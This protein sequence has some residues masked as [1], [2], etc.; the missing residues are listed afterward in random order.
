MKAAI[1]EE[2]GKIEVCEIKDPEAKEGFS[3]IKVIEATL[4]PID[5]FTIMG[6]RTVK[7]IPHIPGVEV[8]GEVVEG[9]YK[10]KK[11]VVYPRIFCGE[12]EYC[13]SG[14][15][16][17]CTGELFGV[18]TNGGFAELCLVP[19]KNIFPIEEKVLPEVASSLPVGAL[20]SYHALKYANFGDRVAVIGA[21][22]NTGIFSVQIAKLKGCEVF[23]WSRKKANWLKE[24][25]ADEVLN[26]E[27]V[28]KFIGYFDI[29]IDPLGEKTFDRSIKLIKKGGTFITFGILTGGTVS[30]NIFDLYSKE[31]KIIGTTGGSRKEFS[32]LISISE[33]LKTK[34]WKKIKLDDLK[35]AIEEMGKKEG[36]IKV[37]VA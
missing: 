23:A 4:N 26:Y 13:F 17:L 16:M 21:T 3:V 30:L 27:S 7:P 2:F 28:E 29:V 35:S 34:V 24:F 25:G 1:L 18:S 6:R 19:D 37:M 33:K 12:C 9:K 8:Y 20:T 32:E 31:I 5:I 36:V 10:G 15:E 11:V 14:R 22:G